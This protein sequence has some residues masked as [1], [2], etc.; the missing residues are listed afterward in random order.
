MLYLPKEG[1]TV[2]VLT[3]VEHALDVLIGEKIAS[4]VVG[5][6]TNPSRI[7]WCR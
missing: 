4:I 3:N 5:S 6:P 1:V 2:I 7:A